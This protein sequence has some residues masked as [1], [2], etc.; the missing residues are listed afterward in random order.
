MDVEKK[1]TVLYSLNHV[2]TPLLIWYDDNELQE[3]QYMTITTDEY[4]EYDDADNAD[5]WW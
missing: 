2:N 4:D 3:W 5:D 1:L